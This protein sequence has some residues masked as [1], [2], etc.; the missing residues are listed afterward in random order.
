MNSKLT[1]LKIALAGIGAVLIAAQAAP[2]QQAPVT[3]PLQ[4][5][6]NQG[7]GDDLSNIFNGSSNTGTSMMGL[8]NRIMLMDGRSADEFS[9]DQQ[10]GINSAA[11]EFRNKQRLQLQP[12]TITPE[13]TGVQ[14]V[15]PAP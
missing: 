12:G 5:I 1:T 9:A 7:G 11:L 2:A 6:Q 10:E 13:A 14:P 4:D 15:Q 8:M 3:N